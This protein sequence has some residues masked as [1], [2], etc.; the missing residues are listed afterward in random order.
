MSLVVNRIPLRHNS[1]CSRGNRHIGD[2]LFPFLMN[3]KWRMQEMSSYEDS[4][5][6]NR[7]SIALYQA[8]PPL[9]M[10]C[11]DN[12]LARFPVRAIQI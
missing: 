12:G 1:S 5:P 6:L 11:L 9:T 8:M 10:I 2:F 4:K 3:I 7:V